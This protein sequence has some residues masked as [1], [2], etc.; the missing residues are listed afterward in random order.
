MNMQVDTISTMLASGGNASMVRKGVAS[1]P[2]HGLGSGKDL[3]LK[4]DLV[5]LHADAVAHPEEKNLS[6]EDL[7]IFL[8]M[9]GS[10]RVSRELFSAITDRVHVERINELLTSKAG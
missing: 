3:S 6:R 1:V 5:E 8:L 2:E 9:L 10:N 4:E 7:D